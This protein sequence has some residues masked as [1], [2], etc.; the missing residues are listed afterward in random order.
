M[1]DKQTELLL[2]EIL[3]QTKA[4]ANASSL[5][6]SQVVEEQVDIPQKK[7]PSFLSGILN[8]AKSIA[9]IAV[10]AINP[11][12]GAAT[13]AILSTLNDDEWFAEYKPAGATFSEILKASKMG[14][15]YAPV[16][17]IVPGFAEIQTDF[18]PIQNSANEDTRFVREVM[19]SIL[20]YIRHETNNVLVDDVSQYTKAFIAMVR[21]YSIYYTLRKYEKLAL[22]IPENNGTLPLA[23][24]ALK[25]EI[26]NQLVGIADSLQGYLKSTCGLPYALAEYL[27]W[28]YGTTFNSDNTGRPGLIVYDPNAMKLREDRDTNYPAISWVVKRKT[29]KDLI[30]GLKEVIA[31]L[32]IRIQG[33]GRAAADIALAYKNHQVRYD[34]E[35]RHYDEKEYNLR[36]N[37][38]FPGRVSQGKQ[39][40]IM[41]DSRLDSSAAIQAVTLNTLDALESS[42]SYAM[43]PLV[44][45]SG[46]NYEYEI[47]YT[48]KMQSPFFVRDVI[49][50]VNGIEESRHVLG[51][52]YFNDGG[53]RWPI[54]SE[55]IKGTGWK[56]VSVS[57]YCLTITPYTDPAE[58]TTTLNYGPAS[59]PSDLGAHGD[60]EQTVE[61]FDVEF[62][63]YTTNSSTPG[64]LLFDRAIIEACLIALQMHNQSVCNIGNGDE[65]FLIDTLAYDTATINPSQLEA[66]Q[67]MAMRN[68][69]RGDYKGKTTQPQEEAK[70][71][72]VDAVK[73]VEK[74]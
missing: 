11:A 3:A 34:V 49:F 51:D 45:T 73:A 31:K 47:Q 27:R 44:S 10:G 57:E 50:L 46:A 4:G 71:A 26:Y 36:I 23:V 62:Y 30:E 67:L 33:S 2:K 18:A 14:S 61:Q 6:P 48:S 64:E 21:L 66:I 63:K 17:K 16:Y 41:L 40:M 22:Y 59:G 15:N 60:D 42:G 56:W 35:D 58:H 32:Q 39:Y 24:N 54:S 5:Q 12:A 29:D 20:A 55:T 8:A 70:E 69:T 43:T 72:L 9:P 25:P 53:A 74:K 28:R 1:M 52:T 38:T 65:S 13:K 37:S 19:P 7:A 68:L